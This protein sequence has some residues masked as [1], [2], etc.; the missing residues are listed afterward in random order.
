MLNR[1]PAAISAIL[2]DERRYAEKMLRD[3]DLGHAKLIIAAVNAIEAALKESAV[4]DALW[5]ARRR[6]RE[7]WS[8]EDDVGASIFGRVLRLIS[9]RPG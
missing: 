8:D 6:Y 3:G 1:V 5:E 9:P 4:E 2:S 7:L